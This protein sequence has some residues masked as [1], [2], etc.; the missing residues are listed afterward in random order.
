MEEG[1][2]VDSRQQV[3]TR[4]KVKVDAQHRGNPGDFR[5]HPALLLSVWFEPDGIFASTIG[6]QDLTRSTAPSK[7]RH[8]EEQEHLFS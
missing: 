6:Y 5:D 4:W 7:A 1:G 8:D 2:G 3:K